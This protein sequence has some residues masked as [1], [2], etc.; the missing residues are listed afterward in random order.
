MAD[1]SLVNPKALGKSLT[2]VVNVELD[3]ERLDLINEFKRAM[4]AERK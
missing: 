4:R 2:V 3:R 1:I